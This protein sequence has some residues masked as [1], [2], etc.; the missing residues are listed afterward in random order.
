MRSLADVFSFSDDLGP[1][2]VVH[3]AEQGIG[4]KGI[5]VVDNVAAGPS[6]GGLRIA[7]DE[8]RDYCGEGLAHF[9]VPKYVRFV[10]EF[11]MTVT[12]KLQKFRMREMEIETLG[13]KD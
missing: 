8:L 12:G 1:A 5:L 9:M 10:T 3:V 2:L 11:P 4:L 7:E 6:I 13:L